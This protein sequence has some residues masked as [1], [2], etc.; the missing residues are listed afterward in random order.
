[1]N[2]RVYLRS[3][4]FAHVRSSTRLR[5]RGEEK[6]CVYKHNSFIYYLLLCIIKCSS[7]TFFNTLRNQPVFMYEPNEAEKIA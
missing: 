6:S 7:D 5:C 3:I 2:F 1:M 4:S